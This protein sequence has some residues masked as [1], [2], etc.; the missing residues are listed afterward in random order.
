MSY[1]GLATRGDD[2]KLDWSTLKWLTQAVERDDGES[3]EKGG[4]KIDSQQALPTFRGW[5]P[6]PTLGVFCVPDY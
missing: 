3:G 6:L 5:E 2:A 4:R 1:Y